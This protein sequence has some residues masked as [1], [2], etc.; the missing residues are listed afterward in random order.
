MSAPIRILIA[1]DHTLIR[2]SLAKVLAMEPD[3]CVV[4]Q[5]IDGHHAVELAEYLQPD[6]VLM[7]IGMPRLN[8]VEATRRLCQAH[9]NIRVLALSTY[10]ADVMAEPILDAGAV[11][12]IQ[13]DAPLEKLLAAI[14]AACGSD[15]G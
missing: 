14:R 3:L 10:N 13:K 4:G 7:D 8:G 11:A 2:T 12:Y 5:A 9:P 1:D 6:V 15:A